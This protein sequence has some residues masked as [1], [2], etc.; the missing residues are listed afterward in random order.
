MPRYT[1]QPKLLN[2]L[3]NARVVNSYMGKILGTLYYIYDNKLYKKT[4]DGKYREVLPQKNSRGGNYRFYIIK[5]KGRYTTMSR[6]SAKMLDQ[7]E[8]LIDDVTDSVDDSLADAFSDLGNDVSS[9]LDNDV[10]TDFTSIVAKD[11]DLMG[12][13]PH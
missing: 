12:G 11:D 13:E 9:N 7:M 2:E 8:F 6:V 4:K 10:S 5:N 3:P 1:T